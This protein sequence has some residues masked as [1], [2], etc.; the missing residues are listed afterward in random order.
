[1]GHENYGQNSAIK[2]YDLFLVNKSL[3]QSFQ[4]LEWK[5]LKMLTFCNSRFLKFIIF[6]LKLI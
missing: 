6:R 4:R 1:M 5:A 3:W 2:P